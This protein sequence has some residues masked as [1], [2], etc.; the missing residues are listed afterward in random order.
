MTSLLKE[1]YAAFLFSHNIIPSLTNATGS[2]TTTLQFPRED[3]LECL[4]SWTTGQDL[5]SEDTELIVI[6]NGSRPRL[7]KEVL[8]ILR[9]QDQ[10]V[11]LETDNEMERG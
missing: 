1:K 5:S 10:F 11:T 2:V 6:S 9:E 8:T 4:Q 3:P 7:E